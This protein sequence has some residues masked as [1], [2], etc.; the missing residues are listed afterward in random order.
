MVL[1]QERIVAIGGVH[2]EAGDIHA[3][4]LH[5][6]DHLVRLAHG[7]E[8]VAGDPNHEAS[9]FDSCQGIGK[10]RVTTGDVVKVDRAGEIEITIRIEAFDKLLTLVVEVALDI[11]T[12]VQVVAE[13]GLF[14]LVGMGLLSAVLIV[15][16]VELKLREEHDVVKSA[17]GTEVVCHHG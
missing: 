12:G 13:G 5:A 15:I 8:I 14:L 7:E 4:F 11:K 17:S 9:G 2:D 1:D 16:G 10:R 3:A 6:L